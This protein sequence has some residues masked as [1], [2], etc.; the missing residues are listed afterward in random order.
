MTKLQL[1]WDLLRPL[2]EDDAIAIADIHGVYGFMRVTVSPAGD[3]LTV[4]YDATRLSESDV[5]NWL[6][7]YG[8]PIRREPVAAQ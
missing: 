8:L 4:E 2:T 6:V 3:R 1:Q 7:R 5:E